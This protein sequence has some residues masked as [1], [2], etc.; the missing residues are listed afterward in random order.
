MESKKILLIAAP[1]G[2][3]HKKAAEAVGDAIKALE[4]NCAVTLLD[5]FDFL[6][7]KLVW[8]CLTGYLKSLIYFPKLYGNAYHWGNKSRLAEMSRDVLSFLLVLK[9]KNY[10]K[11]C[12]PDAIICTHASAAAAVDCLLAKEHLNIYH[13]A[14]VT[15]FVVHRLWINSTVKDYFIY[16]KSIL[17]AEIKA[18]ILPDK[19]QAL[20]IPIADTFA[21]RAK[22][23][24][25]FNLAHPKTILIMGGGEGLL[26]MP[27]LLNVLNEVNMP[28]K[29]VV[30]TGH[31]Q[32][33]KEQLD[34]M[35]DLIKHSIL[36]EKFVDNVAELMR[37]ADLM[38]SKAGGISISE[39][40][41]IGLPMLIY[42]PLPGQERANMDFLKEKK[43]AVEITDIGDFPQ[44]IDKIFRN[45]DQ[46]FNRWRL[47]LNKAAKPDAAENIAKYILNKLYN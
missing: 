25:R 7:R 17:N 27:H 5:I 43:L 24:F 4:P 46:A 45:D 23:S 20:G 33:L 12:S 3:G 42:R 37:N 8:L 6:P 30:L 41:S 11:R 14:V 9:L 35:K 2:C 10:V 19:I 15:D 18:L 38:I 39:A 21:I 36:V 47:N 32:K 40:L 29:L 22:K 16:D 26:P 34:G 1:I 31:N 13:A 44:V 28:L